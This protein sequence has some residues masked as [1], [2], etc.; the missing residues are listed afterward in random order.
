MPTCKPPWR[1]PRRRPYA[2]AGTGRRPAGAAYPT[3][4][5]RRYAG[6]VC[7]RCNPKR[8]RRQCRMGGNLS[9]CAGRRG[10]YGCGRLALERPAGRKA[11]QLHRAGG[12]AKRRLPRHGVVAG[13]HAGYRRHNPKQL[14]QRSGLRCPYPALGTTA[15]GAK[16]RDHRPLPFRSVSCISVWGGF[17]QSSSMIFHSASVSLMVS[18]MVAPPFGKQITTVITGR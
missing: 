13:S 16:Q 12:C 10:A 14:G 17:S 11:G 8:G 15:V 3:W 7:C 1:K 4:P 5:D 6:A 18:S 2:N 9:A